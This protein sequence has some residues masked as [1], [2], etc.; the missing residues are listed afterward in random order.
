VP[1][2][3]SIIGEVCF[4]TFLPLGAFGLFTIVI[5]NAYGKKLNSAYASPATP[6]STRG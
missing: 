6:P 5:E 1:A 2:M 3:I 4:L